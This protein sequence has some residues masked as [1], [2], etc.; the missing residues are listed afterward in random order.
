MA[1]IIKRKKSYSV[2]YN[3]TDENGEVKQ[4]W[5]TCRNHQD[6]LKRKAEVENDLNKGTFIPPNDQTVREF[7]YD[8]VTMYGE[9]K[10]GVSMYDMSTGMIENYINPLIG[11]L[12]IQ[13]ITTRTTDK[14]VQALL[15]TP[16]VGSPFR[17]NKEGKMV[18]EKTAEKVIKLLRCAFGQAVR[19]D[20]I[21]KNPF[22]HTL[23]RKTTYTR[24][25]IW[26]AE[27]IMKALNECEDSRLYIAMNLSF[28]C[29]LRVGEILGLT[30][31]NV[32]IT[33]EDIANDDAWIYVDKELERVSK[34]SISALG[35][36]NIIKVFV[37]LMPNT[38]TRVILKT[39][40]TESSIRKVWLPKTLAYILK[41]WQKAQNEL[42]EYLGEEYQDY[43]LVLA[44]PNG[45]PCENRI[46]A[47][48]FEKLK[49]K[50]N[51]PN[52][53]FHSLRH[54]STT[55]KLKLN[56]G[57]LKATQ[58]DTGHA[59]IDMIT[60]IYAHILDEDRKIN[61]QKFETAFYG[62]RDLRNVRNPDAA[63]NAETPPQGSQSQT[64]DLASLIDQIQKNPELANTL[65]ALIANGVKANS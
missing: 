49:K 55:Y 42:K 14:F 1:S 16:A 33:D 45:R 35:E 2:V 48:E 40:K 34:R 6:A 4:K 15:K 8:F 13:S 17:P 52:V 26:D 43:N 25:D 22:E 61:A 50:A 39:P 58:G 18:T 21:S 12:K 24:R 23:C 59:Q 46:I 47:K 11:D 3:Y 57:D 36:K 51:L 64:L 27:T 5:E 54:S 63:Q 53:V 20:L 65:A 9:Q 29:S 28:A 56:H 31:D 44:L 32:H 62:T 19:W 41:E 30:W 7:M 10:W 60:D 38:S 37:P